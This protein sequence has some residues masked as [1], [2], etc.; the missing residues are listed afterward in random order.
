MFVD[1]EG[2][3]V[4]IANIFDPGS[5]SLSTRPPAAITR[6]G[7]RQ[8][9]LETNTFGVRAVSTAGIQVDAL[10]KKDYQGYFINEAYLFAGGKV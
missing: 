6:L 10:E 4:A 3:A 8:E 1:E 9:V 5:P 2:S 7:N